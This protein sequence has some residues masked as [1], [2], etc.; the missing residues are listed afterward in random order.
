MYKL[1]KSRLATLPNYELKVNML[2]MPSKSDFENLI[3]KLSITSYSL[4][5]I[6]CFTSTRPVFYVVSM[7]QTTDEAQVLEFSNF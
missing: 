4:R 7:K 5:N 1:D 2:E 6:I 3:M